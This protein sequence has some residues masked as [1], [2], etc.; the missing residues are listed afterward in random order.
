MI[1]PQIYQEKEAQELYETMV[2]TGIK[3]AK[4]DRV[5]SLQGNIVSECY[6]DLFE[7]CENKLLSY[8]ENA[9]IKLKE[10]YFDE[11]SQS[12]LKYYLSPL[13]DIVSYYKGLL[14]NAVELYIKVSQLIETNDPTSI[15]EWDKKQYHYIPFIWRDY[16]H[17][18]KETLNIEIDFLIKVL[19]EKFVSVEVNIEENFIK[20]NG[21]INYLDSTNNVRQNT[22][23]LENPASRIFN[24]CGYKLF[25]ALLPV[26][27][28]HKNGAS[29]IE[30]SFYFL[31]MKKDKLINEFTTNVEFIIWL[32][33]THDIH[34][35]Q[36]DTRI[37][38]RKER[39]E[40]Y[41]S[42]KELIKL[43]R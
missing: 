26:I 31:E 5:N 23:M 12:F 9:N 7:S 43:N 25:E 34:I 15:F 6:Q 19:A 16:L 30:I 29:Q 10:A 1:I 32:G 3:F 18:I 40:I 41:N 35:S 37:S 33:N 13:S 39:L 14:E 4:V 20:F 8:Y 22:T 11:Y 38:K 17:T 28:T 21:I 2:N 36:I 24:D 42:K 27:K